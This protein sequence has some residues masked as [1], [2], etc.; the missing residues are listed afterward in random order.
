M[1]IITLPPRG[2]IDLKGIS[3]LKGILDHILA[4]GHKHIKGLIHF[5]DHIR[6]K[7]ILNLTGHLHIMKYMIHKG[8]THHLDLTHPKGFGNRRDILIVTWM[9]P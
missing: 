8:H 6:L 1:R 7:E 5:I 3:N 4:I 9:G 2:M